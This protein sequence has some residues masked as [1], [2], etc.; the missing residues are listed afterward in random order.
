MLVLTIKDGGYFYIDGQPVRVLIDE[1]YVDGKLV[2][3]V[4]FEVV[5]LPEDY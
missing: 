2:K 5:G 1:F 4:E 3:M